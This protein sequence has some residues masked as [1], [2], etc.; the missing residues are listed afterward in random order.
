LD[1]L[2]AQIIITKRLVKDG[3]PRT[4]F[5]SIIIR[6]IQINPPNNFVYEVVV[7]EGGKPWPL[8]NWEID[9][10]EK[11]IVMIAPLVSEQAVQIDKSLR[12]TEVPDVWLERQLKML[13]DS[14]AT[15]LRELDYLHGITKGFE[16]KL[17]P[18]D[19][20]FHPRGNLNYNYLLMQIKSVLEVASWWKDT[21]YEIFA[22]QAIKHFQKLWDALKSQKT[23]V[24]EECH[25]SEREILSR[26]CRAIAV[27]E[28]DKSVSPLH[29]E[30]AFNVYSAILYEIYNRHDPS[31]K[32]KFMSPE[33]IKPR[34]SEIE[35]F[36]HWCPEISR[37]TVGLFR[38][39]AS[40]I[41]NRLLDR[42][43]TLIL[44]DDLFWSGK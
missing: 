35:I 20:F 19:Y 7:N 30:K 44:N 8:G 27:Y 38:P 1:E 41:I 34:S 6:M 31:K 42:T 29:V 21:G 17:K 33:R 22:P 39:N 18:S 26:L 24:G 5:D 32:D 36:A 14:E 13:S 9:L 15:F 11:K 16:R 40:W 23:S 3:L 37:A 43:K 25:G 12:E 4:L 10:Q 2:E 28:Q